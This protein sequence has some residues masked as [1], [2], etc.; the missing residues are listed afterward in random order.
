VCIRLS[1]NVNISLIIEM[2]EDSKWISTQF[3]PV[4]LF[5]TNG[6]IFMTP[7]NYIQLYKIIYIF[8]QLY[9]ITYEIVFLEF[10]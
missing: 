6:A 4:D 3:S 7:C 9:I 10:F 1:L 8:I 2:V 5:G